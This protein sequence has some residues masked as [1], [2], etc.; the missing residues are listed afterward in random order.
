MNYV[1][2]SIIALQFQ[3]L[4]LSSTGKAW[5]ARFMAKGILQPDLIHSFYRSVPK[6]PQMTV[7]LGN[8]VILYQFL[9]VISMHN[10]WFGW[11]WQ[12]LCQAEYVSHSTEEAI[13]HYRGGFV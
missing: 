13:S 11:N 12:N 9:L 4:F 10:L 5:P 1:F 2:L 3:S 6:Q 8:W 7:P